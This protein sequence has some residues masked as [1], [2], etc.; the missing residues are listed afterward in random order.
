[1][2]YKLAVKMNCTIGKIEKN[3]AFEDYYERLFGGRWTLLRENLLLPAASVS[4]SEGLIKPYMLDRASVLAAMSLTLP[5]SGTILDACAAPGGKSLVLA[6]RLSGETRLLCNELSAER[7]RRLRNTLNEHLDGDK[8]RQVS[9]SGFDA[10][11]LG[12]IK[13]EWNRFEAILL[14][15]PCSSERHIIQSP[16][17]LAEWTQARP[18]FLSRR[19]WSLLSAAFLLLK[20]GGSLVYSTC[21]LSPIENDGPVSRL[22]EKYACAIEL[23][24]PDFAEGEKTKYGRLILPDVSTGMGPMY[25]ARFRKT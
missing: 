6:S 22:L 7:R 19:Q 23:D 11:A 17:A 8:L 2:S 9:I 3:L 18:R 10:A 1:L 15:A 21:A 4:Y 25:V 13:S 14:D 16:R 24:D 20:P 5:A 12:G